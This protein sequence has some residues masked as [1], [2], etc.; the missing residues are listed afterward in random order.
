MIF[1]LKIIRLSPQNKLNKYTGFILK[2]ISF[3]KFE[4]NF[5]IRR[6]Y[7]VK[8]IIVY[9]CIDVIACVCVCTY[10]FC[11][12]VASAH[13]R[14]L[15]GNRGPANA[16]PNALVSMFAEPFLSKTWSPWKRPAKRQRRQLPTET[17]AFCANK[18]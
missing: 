18:V 7:I 10:Q 1:Y 11:S 13:P 2:Y 15:R 4:P 12:D 5:N 6:I 8:Y 16:V 9:W 17:T 14:W 3:R